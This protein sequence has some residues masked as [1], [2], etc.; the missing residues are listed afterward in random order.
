MYLS[1][2]DAGGRQPKQSTFSFVI[3]FRCGKLLSKHLNQ[4]L[5]LPKVFIRVE[6]HHHSKEKRKATTENTIRSHKLVEK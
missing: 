6:I 2:T 1:Q 5:D 4:S 3:V